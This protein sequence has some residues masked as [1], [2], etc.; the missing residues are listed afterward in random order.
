M[1]TPQV[2]Y[3]AGFFLPQAKAWA[4]QAGAMGQA[5][6]ESAALHINSGSIWPFSGAVAAYNQ[7]CTQFTT[8]SGEGVNQMFAI[9]DALCESAQ[10]YGATE[11]QLIQA[12]D[13]TWNCRP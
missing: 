7:V 1:G 3:S 5:G 8:W 6:S 9:C 4:D 13:G 2:D 12:S 11:Q 10:R